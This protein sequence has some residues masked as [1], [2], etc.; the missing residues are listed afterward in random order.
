MMVTLVAT[1][2]AIVR[3]REVGTFEQLVVTPAPRWILVA[4]KLIPFALFGA[5]DTMVILAVAHFWFRIPID[6]HVALLLASAVPYLF[7]T[8]GLGLF[9]S[10][11]SRTQQQAMMTAMF[12]VMLPMIYLSGFVFPVESMPTLIQPLTEVIPL[13]HF[14]III[15]GVMLKGAGF[16]ELQRP[17]LTLIGLGVAIF[18][19][20][21]AA[22]R[23]RSD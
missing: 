5:F 21:V 3:E 18:G 22:F 1:S 8:L 17:I 23:K 2:M 13:R 7:C 4:G 6:G 12:F 20:S 10:T 11:V 16:S 15:R 19:L 9:V 14:L